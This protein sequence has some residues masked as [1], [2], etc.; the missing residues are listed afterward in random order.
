MN[1][2][3]HYKRKERP[4][5]TGEE[6]KTHRARQGRPQ[7]RIIARKTKSSLNCVGE[8]LRRQCSCR[9]L[10]VAPQEDYPNDAEIAYGI[11]PE[12]RCNPGADDYCPGQRRTDRTTD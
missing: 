8:P 11:K 4:V 10:L 3:V 2:I 9:L 5:S 7:V 6:E 1:L 12:W